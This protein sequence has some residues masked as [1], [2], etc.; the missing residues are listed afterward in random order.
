MLQARRHSWAAAAHRTPWARAG[1]QAAPPLPGCWRGLPWAGAEP[2]PAHAQVQGTTE[3]ERAAAE[4]AEREAED[5][6]RRA[7][8]EQVQRMAHERR[9]REEAAQRAHNLALHRAQQVPPC[10]WARPGPACA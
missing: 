1:S 9:E 5:A 4:Q 8:E 3:E 6:E 10:A 2:R 7:A